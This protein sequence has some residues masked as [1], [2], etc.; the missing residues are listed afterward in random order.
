MESIMFTSRILTFLAVASVMFSAATPALAMGTS[1]SYQGSLE[2]GNAP[3]HGSYDFEFRL[4]D[5]VGG[6]LANNLRDNVEVVHGV[7]T[8]ELNFGDAGVAFPGAFVRFL[9]IG[10]RPSG[11]A[12]AYEFLAPR[13][14]IHPAPYAQRAASVTNGAILEASIAASA[15]TNTRLANSSVSSAKLA[16]GAVTNAKLADGA[17]TTVK[18]ANG[19]IT[20]AKVAAGTLTMSRHAGVFFNGSIGSLTVGAGACI[21][22]NI[23][24]VGALAGDFPMVALQAGQSLPTGMTL[25]ATRVPSN[26]QMELRA[27]NVGNATSNWSGLNLIF[28]TVR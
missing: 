19:A 2:D 5:S 12:S 17:V 11:S 8:V 16:D 4:I 9:E 18:I 23:P 3:A 21:N 14:P 7:F 15:V 13:T 27:C 20:N 10:I 28:M 22:F 25:T 26:G 24:I 6:T 1:F